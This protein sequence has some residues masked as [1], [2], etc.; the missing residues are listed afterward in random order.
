MNI[1]LYKIDGFKYNVYRVTKSHPI[2]MEVNKKMRFKACED[3]KTAQY[4]K[5]VG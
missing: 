1:N 2:V 5:G 4:Q 3:L